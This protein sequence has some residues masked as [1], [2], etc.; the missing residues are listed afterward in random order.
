MLCW[1]SQFD[2]I[3]QATGSLLVSLG[4]LKSCQ[5]GWIKVV[6]VGTSSDVVARRHRMQYKTL[7]DVY[8]TNSASYCSIL[9]L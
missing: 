5:H 9:S 4:V 6:G 3:E 1:L 2:S 8:S 7:F